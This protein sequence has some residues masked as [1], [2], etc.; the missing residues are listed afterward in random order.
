MCGH[1]FKITSYLI[2]SCLNTFSLGVIELKNKEFEKIK[3]MNKKEEEAE[4]FIGEKGLITA[5]EKLM[6]GSN[7][8]EKG[9]FFYVNEEIY[10]E[11]VERFY[12]KLWYLLKI[13][14]N[15]W[16]GISHIGLKN[17]K[18]SKKYPKFVKQYYVNFPVPGNIDIINDKILLTSWTGNIVG[19]LIH[20]KEM[21]ESYRKYFESI[22]LMQS[23]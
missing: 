13:F 4:V 18:I 22:K 5:Y 17:K 21:A 12:V 11:K 3:E 9:Y 7:K 6:V 15:E 8:N 23:L 14:G 19:I 16:E 1:L 10:Y 2:E 20:S